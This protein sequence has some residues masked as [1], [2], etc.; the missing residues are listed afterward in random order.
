MH[1]VHNLVFSFLPFWGRGVFDCN[2]CNLVSVRKKAAI[3][4]NV[5]FLIVWFLGGDALV[6][7]YCM[8]LYI[9]KN[10]LFPGSYPFVGSLKIYEID[11]WV[12]VGG[13]GSWRLKP[14]SGEFFKV[15]E[16]WWWGVRV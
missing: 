5:W 8:E 2:I 1:H 12:E 13:K 11:L 15:R 10:P 6:G 7:D 3:T 16:T 14:G 9:F 4:K